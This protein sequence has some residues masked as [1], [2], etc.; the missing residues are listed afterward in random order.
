GKRGDASAQIYAARAGRRNGRR[1]TRIAE[2][3]DAFAW[4]PDGASF[5]IVRKDPPAPHVAPGGPR[6]QA[7]LGVSGPVGGAPAPSS[8]Q[9]DRAGPGDEEP[10]PIV[11]TRTQIQSDSEGFLGDRRKHLW[12]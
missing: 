12:V 10:D 5:V 1:M 4:S 11:V 3:V 8:G 7:D 9:K 2:G 6:Q